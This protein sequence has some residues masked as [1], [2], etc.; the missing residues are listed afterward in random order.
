MRR[1]RW[2]WLM[3]PLFG[4]LELL[5]HC[6]FAH[7]APTLEE[8]R[9]EKASVLSLRQAGEPVLVA[10]Y[11]AEP[12]A[13][14]ALGDEAFSLF[15]LA[16]PDVTAFRR[17]VEVSVLGQRSP[18]IAGWRVVQEQWAGRLKL[19]LLENPAPAE[20]KFD[21]WSELGPQKVS[22]IEQGPPV[23]RLCPHIRGVGST[24]GLHGHIAFP[25]ERFQCPSGAH[26]FVGRTVV[27]DQAYRPRRC[28]WAHPPQGRV[29]V[30]R[31]TDVPLGRVVRGYGA[32]SWFLWRDGGNAPVEL[33]ARVNGEPIGTW[34]HRE[35]QGWNGFEFATGRHAAS[36]ATVEFRIRS[37]RANGR[38]FCFW[39]D[40]R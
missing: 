32:L 18:E 8:W 22:V 13:R 29:L 1:Y 25:A 4:L 5:S 10:P 2:L 35:E 26:V 7:R 15:D 33:E 38:E 16:R 19:T 11:W 27:E 28:L 40:T 20:V 6:H 39:A 9:A 23:D 34:V 12:M 36:R 3:V 37:D 31:Y 30:L 21:F 24:G 17:V 14:H